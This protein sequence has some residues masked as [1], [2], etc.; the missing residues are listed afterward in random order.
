MRKHAVVPADTGDNNAALG[1]HSEGISTVVCCRAF[2]RSC[3]YR[4]TAARR[5]FYE[6]SRTAAR[7][8]AVSFSSDVNV[9]GS[10]ESYVMAHVITAAT[11]SRGPLKVASGIK[12]EK[13]EVKPPCA[14]A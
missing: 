11:P 9:A 2:P 10:V 13:E 5:K 3:P 7:P 6:H 14:E 8:K 1:I 4:R 12:L